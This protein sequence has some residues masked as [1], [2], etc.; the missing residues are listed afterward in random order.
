MLRPFVLALASIWLGACGV[1]KA[2]LPDTALPGDF[3]T[4]CNSRAP[5]DRPLVVAWPSTEKATLESQR[6]QGLVA[7]RWLGC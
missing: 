4:K 1:S 7:V 3:V 2:A 5:D 6:K